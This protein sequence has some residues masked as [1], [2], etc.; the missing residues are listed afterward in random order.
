MNKRFRK[1]ATELSEEELSDYDVNNIDGGKADD[2]SL[3]DLADKHNVPIK[4][5]LKELLVGMEVELEHTDDEMVAIEISLDH[6]WEFP[7]YYTRLLEL[8]KT[9]EEELKV[10]NKEEE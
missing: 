9:M 4:D 5:L 2:L 8:E 10:K 7:Q 6:I 3:K 1:I